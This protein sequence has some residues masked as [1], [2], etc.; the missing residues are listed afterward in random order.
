MGH[1]GLEICLF[2]DPLTSL[3]AV[4]VAGANV[5][6]EVNN[7]GESPSQKKRTV[8]ND[9]LMWAILGLN[10][11]PPDYES[12]ALTN[13]AKS[14]S[15]SFEILCKGMAKSFTLQIFYAKKCNEPW[16]ATFSLLFLQGLSSLSVV[17]HGRLA[18][19]WDSLIMLSC[20]NPRGTTTL[21]LF[22]E[23]VPVRGREF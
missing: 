6:N 10:Q 2:R 19:G 13:W 17:W 3:F 12:V 8:K 18:V 15:I 23:G 20:H 1:L 7:L 4:S 11:G 9:S 22:K 16:T 14:P 21:P 5:H